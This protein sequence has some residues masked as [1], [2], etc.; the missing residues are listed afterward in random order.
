MIALCLLAEPQEPSLPTSHHRHRRRQQNRALAELTASKAELVSAL[1][2]ELRT[3]L[4]AALAVVGLL[5]ER[6]GDPAVDDV[7]PILG[8]NLHRIEDVVTEIATISGL[9]NG[10]LPLDH[11][12]FSLPELLSEVATE[13][14]TAVSL[15]EPP[16]TGADVIGDRNRIGQVF[17]RMLAA[18]R[19]LGGDGTMHVTE[20]DGHWRVAFRLPS[21]QPTD[22][23]FT[24]P[25]GQ[26]NAMA[27]ML[28]RA[29]VGRHNGQ[30]AVETLDDTPYLS[31][32]LP[33]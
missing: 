23:L 18:V 33:H 32:T 31:T 9:E 25:G 10:T 16:V 15:P 1:L 19:A 12:P 14:G 4:A 11:R 7:L 2:H 6:T 29:V 5:P 22:R 26:G 13:A 8:R 27:L 30:V 20:E 24:G 28:A 21:E 17:R 3:P